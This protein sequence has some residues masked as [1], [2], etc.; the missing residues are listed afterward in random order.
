MLIVVTV[1]FAVL[2]L[3][4]RSWVVYNSFA[5]EH[6]RFYNDW[7]YLFIKIMAYTNSAMNPILYR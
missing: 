4:Y 6:K 5:A 1:L 3:P 2:W 7:F